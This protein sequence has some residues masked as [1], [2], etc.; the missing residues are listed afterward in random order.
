MHQ[1]RRGRHPDAVSLHRQSASGWPISI[2]RVQAVPPDLVAADEGAADDARSDARHLRAAVR[3]P[4]GEGLR[5]PIA[6]WIDHVPAAVQRDRKT[7]VL[8]VKP[9][10]STRRYDASWKKLGADAGDLATGKASRS[11]PA[12]TTYAGWCCTASSSPGSTAG[13]RARR[14]RSGQA[15][16]GGAQLPRARRPS[17]EAIAVG[18]ASPISISWTGTRLH[19]HLRSSAKAGWCSRTGRCSTPTRSTRAGDQALRPARRGRTPAWDALRAAEAGRGGTICPVRL[20]LAG[21]VPE[22]SNKRCS[23]ARAG[24]SG[25][26][27]GALARRRRCT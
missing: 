14:R 15:T 17:W 18:R 9:G 4:S 25:R 6:P 27:S 20:F 24:A 21:V 12:P 13:I 11:C 5:P 26:A 1:A 8:D 2:S 22:L 19:R 16:L 7:L 3:G 23:A 10:A